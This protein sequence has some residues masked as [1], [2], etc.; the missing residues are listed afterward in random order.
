MN[1]FDALIQLCS[2]RFW[3]VSS[4]NEDEETE[5]QRERWQGLRGRKREKER[6]HSEHVSID[7]MEDFKLVIG[8]I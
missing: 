8:N 1:P 4:G 6:E 3:F 2:P 7:E 5:G